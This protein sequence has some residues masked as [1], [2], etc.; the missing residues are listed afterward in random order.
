MATYLSFCVNPSLDNAKYI[1]K[2]IC[3]QPIRLTLFH[4]AENSNF[5]KIIGVVK[6]KLDKSRTYILRLNIQYT[7]YDNIFFLY[8]EREIEFLP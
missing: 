5:Q 8:L 3:T 6:P 4:M 1:I 7:H 2:I